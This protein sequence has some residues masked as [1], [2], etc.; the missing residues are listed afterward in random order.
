MLL[1]LPLAAAMGNG[2]PGSIAAGNSSF[3]VLSLSQYRQLPAHG[4]AKLNNSE[5]PGNITVMIGLNLKNQGKLNALLGNL[6][7]P[8]SP[9]YH[10]YLTRGQF[11]SEFSPSPEEY[12]RAVA[13]FSSFPEINLKTYSDRLSIGITGS[14]SQI[15]MAF[16][17]AISLYSISGRQYYQFEKPSL[18]AW[19][20]SDVSYV[21]GLANYSSASYVAGGSGSAGA[22]LDSSSYSNGYPL[23]IGGGLPGSTQY[24]WGS[25]LQRAY[26]VT[27]IINE[28]N[29]SGTVIADI[30]W[31]NVNYA[32]YNPVD[33]NTYFNETLPPWEKKPRVYGVPLQGADPPGTGARNDSSD[34]TLENTLD[35]EMLGS[36][37]PGASI[38]DVYTLGGT[39]T[40]LDSAM[41]YI[42]NPGNSSSPLNNVSVVSNSWY[43]SDM[44][45]TLWNHYIEEAAARGITVVACS[46]DSGNNPTSEKFVGTGATSPG[47]DAGNSSGVLSVGGANITLDTN[48]AGTG[49]LSVESSQAWYLASD[50][51]NN[52]TPVGTEGG[53]SQSYPE[54]SWQLHSSANSVLQGKGRGVPD[55]SAIAN[56]IVVFITLGNYTYYDSP[57]FYYAWGT[58][59]A[60]PVVSGIIAD[61]DAHFTQDSMGRLGFVNP[62]LYNLSN[63]QYSYR[64]VAVSHFPGFRN[65]FSDVSAGSNAAYVATKGYDLLTGLG[66]INAGNLSYDISGNYSYSYY[67]RNSTIGGY[68]PN[69]MLYRILPISAGVVV[70]AAIAIA[71]FRTRRKGKS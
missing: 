5:S 31:T 60:A 61:L 64:N 53:I 17:A 30:F 62:L 69:L 16:H 22:A 59:I 57:Y 4:T 25:D 70:A 35:L 19:L 67:P 49:F 27:G 18:P 3:E 26:N 8:R 52:P 11:D 6:Q 71:L 46:G 56:H 45:H 47:T 29:L 43:A 28:T 63:I 38:Y 58:S 40:Q 39:F 14:S 33:V 23:P 55:V 32:P 10:R 42:L 7:D 66:Q 44:D 24:I 1:C 54:P 65:P 20:A 9:L 50:T 48:S 51:E 13:Y 41:A 15:S 37:A 36:L 68:L 34:I 21:S 2:G 12:D